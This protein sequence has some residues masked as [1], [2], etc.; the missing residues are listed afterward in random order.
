MIILSCGHSCEDRG[1][2]GWPLKTKSYARDGTK[3][4]R[5][6]DVCKECLIDWVTKEPQ[7]ILVHE[8]E[9]ME[10]LQDD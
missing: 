5:Y 10:W 2:L 8:Y 9:E 7:D 1:G 6:S 3:S 4:V